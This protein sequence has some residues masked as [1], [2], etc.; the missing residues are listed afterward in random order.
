MRP[1]HARQWKQ[2]VWVLSPSAW[3]AQTGWYLAYCVADYVILNLGEDVAMVAF[4][5]S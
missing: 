4:M 2:L 1:S 5:F 3:T